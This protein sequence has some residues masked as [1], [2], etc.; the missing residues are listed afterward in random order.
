MKSKK[1][2]IVVVLALISMFLVNKPAQGVEVL[3][4]PVLVLQE[5]V[6]CD[7]PSVR[8]DGVTVYFDIPNSSITQNIYLKVG[9]RAVFVTPGQKSVAV[10]GLLFNYSYTAVLVYD[11]ADGCCWVTRYGNGTPFTTIM[12]SGI[13]YVPTPEPTPT[14]APSSTPITLPVSET[15]SVTSVVV[16]ET[17][18]VTTTPFVI[19]DT[20]TVISDTKTVVTNTGSTTTSS[21]ATTTNTNTVDYASLRTAFQLVL[22]NFSAFVAFLMTWK[23]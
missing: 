15:L 10:S 14:P 6:N 23:D 4:A 16:T 2:V 7:D 9:P 18:S 1:V 13:L 21:S 11:V 12:V 3:G 8:C 5:K 22:A 19:T 20:P 17:L